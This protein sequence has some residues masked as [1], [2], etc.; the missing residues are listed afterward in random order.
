MILIGGAT[1]QVGDP[2]GKDEMRQQNSDETIAKNIVGIKDSF[3]KFLKFG[4]GANDAVLVN[5]A[6]WLSD[7][8]YIDFFLGNAIMDA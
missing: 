8:N 5:N 1:A 6:D 7:V 3:S 4:N 2:T